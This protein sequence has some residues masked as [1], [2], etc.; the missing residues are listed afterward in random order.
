MPVLIGLADHAGDQV[1]VDLREPNLLNPAIRLHDLGRQMS[2]AILFENLVLEVFDTQRHPSDA[3]FFE[4]FDFLQAE[5]ARLALEGDFV[6]GVP[7]HVLGQFVSQKQQLPRAEIRRR[8]TPEVDELELSIADGRRLADQFDLASQ[9]IDV[10]LNRLSVLVGV[11]PEV[12]EPA[13]LAAER[14]MQ[15]QPQRHTGIRFRVQCGMNLGHVLLRPKRERRIVRDK[16]AADFRRAGCVGR[17]AVA[18]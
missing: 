11:D 3:D 14:D 8:A 1:D 9:A 12:A 6:G 4:C 13:P 7:R 2:A 16:I 5:R 18:L 17:H 15:I 10:T